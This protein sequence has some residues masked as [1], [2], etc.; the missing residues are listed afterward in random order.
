V[1]GSAAL[2][3]IVPTHV[4]TAM[5]DMYVTNVPLELRFSLT[6]DLSL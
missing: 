5:G 1:E 6:T 4:E 3:L 2:P